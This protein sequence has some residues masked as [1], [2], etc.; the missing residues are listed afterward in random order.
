MNGIGMLA[1]IIVQLLLNPS[2]LNVLIIYFFYNLHTCF[3]KNKVIANF[4]LV[5]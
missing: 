2:E 1:Y 4:F 3:A 5:F